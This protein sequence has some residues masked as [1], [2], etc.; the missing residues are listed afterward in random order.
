[1][2]CHVQDPGAE[3]AASLRQ[4]AATHS[5]VDPEPE[6]STGLL[7]VSLQGT[8]HR[9]AGTVQGST[10]VLREL[11]GATFKQ[12]APLAGPVLIYRAKA[13]EPSALPALAGEFPVPPPA[14]GR[15]RG[16]HRI[17]PCCSREGAGV[18]GG[19]RERDGFGRGVRSW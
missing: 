5:D 8:P 15:S 6:G 17:C 1:M 19:D 2:P 18:A 10:P 3:G 14:G 9:A 7:Q 16:G 13:S 11:N 4:V 12:P